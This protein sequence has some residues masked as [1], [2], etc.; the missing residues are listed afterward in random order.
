MTISFKD[1]T[2]R[3]GVLTKTVSENSSLTFSPRPVGGGTGKAEMT[4]L[5]STDFMA[6]CRFAFSV[7]PR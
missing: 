6:L 4:Y 7:L 1:D 5:F 2:K 3:E